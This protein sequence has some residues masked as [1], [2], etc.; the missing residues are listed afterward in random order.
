MMCEIYG[1]TYEEAAY[2]LKCPVG[3]IKSRL[4]NAKRTC[5]VVTR[6]IIKRKDYKTNDEKNFDYGK[7]FNVCI[8][9]NVLCG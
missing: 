4:Y 5:I 9:N 2:K 8:S 7:C 3:T 1:Y 6:F